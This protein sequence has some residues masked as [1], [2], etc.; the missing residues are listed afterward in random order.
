MDISFGKLQFKE[1][2]EAGY[3]FYEL[4]CHVTTM[5]S[6]AWETLVYPTFVIGCSTCKWVGKSTTDK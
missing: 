6:W 4:F 3:L 2:T 1:G 5:I